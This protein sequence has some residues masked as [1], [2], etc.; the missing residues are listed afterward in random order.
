MQLSKYPGAIATLE[1]QVLGMSKEVESL[2]IQVK[3]IEGE[4]D[5]AIGQNTDYKND[6]QRKAARSQALQAH[7]S[8]S[9]LQQS[10]NIQQGEK[11][12]KQI[13][14]NKTINQ[15]S[16]AKLEMQL[17]IANMNKMSA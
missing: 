12:E 9:N 6:T 11:A 8:Y 10:L 15:F 14:L 16:V 7:K 13:E 3:N 1:L 4:V 5:L 17:Q 2:I